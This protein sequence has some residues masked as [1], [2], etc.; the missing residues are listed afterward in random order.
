MQ[1][2]TQWRLLM[3]I[4]LYQFVKPEFL[5]PLLLNLN[6]FHIIIVDQSVILLFLAVLFLAVVSAM[7][8]Y[9]NCLQTSAMTLYPGFLLVKCQVVIDILGKVSYCKLYGIGHVLSKNVFHETPKSS[10][11]Q[12]FKA[13]YMIKLDKTFEFHEI[14]RENDQNQHSLYH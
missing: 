11:E 14:V 8:L 4:R 1:K 9:Q 13:G 7:L 12:S 2:E 6:V 3:L 10:T 5:P